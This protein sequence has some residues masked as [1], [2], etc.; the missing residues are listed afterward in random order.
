MDNI[1]I[2]GGAGFIASHITDLLIDNGY[3]VTILDNLSSGKKSNINLKANFIK[4][5]L[6]DNLESVFKNSSFDCIIHH[7][8][9]I[10]VQTSIEDPFYDAKNNIL[11]TINLL[12]MAKKFAVNKFIYASSAAVYGEPEYLPIDEKHPI[13]PDSPYGISKHTPEH[14]IINF[15]RL[16]NFQYSILRY[17]NVYGPR[18]GAAGEGGVI[19]IFADRMSHNK[20]PIIYG[21]GEQTRDFIYVKDIARANLSALKSDCSGI[22]NISTE[23]EISI[24]KTAALFNKILN[25]DLEPEYRLERPGDIKQSYLSSKKASKKLNWYP[26]TSFSEGIEET[27]SFYL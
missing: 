16:Y 2:T 10:D 25:K 5:D 13:N 8:A 15:S 11:G 1:L 22:F 14:Y 18:Q 4:I 12:Q 17:A 3:N 26:E 21:D 23:K 24:N 9:Q 19:A 27:I 7:A 20:K 6:N